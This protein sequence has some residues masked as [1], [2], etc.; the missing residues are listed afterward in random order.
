MM[1]LV[2]SQAVFGE[3]AM[4]PLLTLPYFPC[5]TLR[6]MASSG[7]Y[8][9]DNGK[10]YLNNCF[11]AKNLLRMPEEGQ[12]T[13]LIDTWASI[14]TFLL[15]QS[16]S[17]IHSFLSNPIYSSPLLYPTS[18]LPIHFLSEFSGSFLSA[19]L[20]IVFPSV[21]LLLIAGFFT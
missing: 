10:P 18:S 8:K 5:L 15:L 12:V 16:D 17:Q 13:S 2:G 21:Q 20:T 3:R 11:P 19:H 6:E 14:D 1:V 7:I 4:L 9:L